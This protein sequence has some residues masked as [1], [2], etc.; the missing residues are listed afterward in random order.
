MSGS[1]DPFKRPGLG[2]YLREPFLSTWQVLV[3]FRL[4][5]LTRSLGDFE[6]IWKFLEANG[7]TLVSVSGQMDFG[8]S[9]GR[10]MGR[11][12]VMFA[13]YE[14]QM[15]QARIKNAYDTARAAGKY[16][17]LQFLFGYVPVKLPGKGWGL[18]PHPIYGTIVE[19]AADRL[20][21]GESLSAICRWLDAE[22]TATPRNAVREYKGKKALQEDAR[23]NQTS[24]AVILKSPAVIGEATVNDGKVQ[25][26]KTLVPVWLSSE[27][28]R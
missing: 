14:R 15:I 27:Q 8:T 16:P 7:K 17:G 20:I 19:Q 21:A 5:R 2:P 12:F 26:G 1:V 22:G 28:S 3:V 4:D 18:E 23:W 13:E 25:R 10:F 24:L 11:Q 6:A 9:T